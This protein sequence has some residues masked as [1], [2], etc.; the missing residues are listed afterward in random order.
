VSDRPQQ[1]VGFTVVYRELAEKL[2]L[3]RDHRVVKV[4]LNEPRYGPPSI[5]VIV[6]GP[7]GHICPRGAPVMFCGSVDEWLPTVDVIREASLEQYGPY[8]W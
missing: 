1:F 8:E 2:N 5:C 7:A 3:P 6:E 4:E